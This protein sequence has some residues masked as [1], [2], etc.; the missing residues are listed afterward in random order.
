M[1]PIYRE[2]DGVADQMQR[3][4][5][6]FK[7]CRERL[8]KGAAVAMFPEGSHRGKKQLMTPLKKGFA[9]LAFTSVEK[10]SRLMSLKIIPM[11]IDYSH[12]L[13]YQPRLILKIGVPI[14]IK[15]YWDQYLEDPNKAINQLVKAANDHLSSLMVDIRDE[16]NYQVLIDLEP[17]FWNQESVHL[18]YEFTKYKKWT[19]QWVNFDEESKGLYRSYHVLLQ[20]MQLSSLQVERFFHITWKQKCMYYIEWLPSFL[21]IVLYSPLYFLAENFIKKNIKD[22]L[23]YN[24]IRLA[25]YTFLSPFYLLFLSGIAIFSFQNLSGLELAIGWFFSISLGLFVISWSKNKRKV[26]DSRRAAVISK[27]DPEK[28]EKLL[29]V[30]NEILTH[31]KEFL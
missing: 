14:A 5:E 26:R 22:E 17:L 18:D 29:N 20:E 23:F 12:F 4:E 3:N 31:G 19:D 1:L 27:K 8:S 2:K 30:R 15:D 25:I 21:G 7:V 13:E 16:E 10:D 24:S 9:R 28:W 11:G 6:V